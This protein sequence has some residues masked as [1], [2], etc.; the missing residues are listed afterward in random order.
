MSKAKKQLA[1]LMKTEP[2]KLRVVK[3]YLGKVKLEEDATHTYQEIKLSGFDA[4]VNNLK[5]GSRM[6]VDLVKEA[7]E[8]RLEGSDDIIEIATLLNCEVWNADYGIDENTDTTILKFATQFQEPLNQQGLTVTE[9]ELLE[10]WH[11]MVDYAVQYLKPAKLHYRVTWYKL[12]HSSRI[13]KWHNILLVVRLLFTLPVSNAATERF[14]STL[15]RVKSP[16]RSS[17]SQRTLQDILRITTEGPP[18]KKYD[19]TNAV[20]AW[21]NSKVRRP[22]QKLKG[23]KPYK[24]RKSG[25]TVIPELEIS[26]RSPTVTVTDSDDS[27]ECDD[28]ESVRQQDV[29]S[30]DDSDTGSLFEDEVE[31]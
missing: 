12:F 11:D 21:H 25:K 6:Y 2:D 22:N 27:R 3:Y 16:K 18:L 15:K 31:L 14:F 26:T 17:L 24:K 7:I 19:A 20:L 30:G 4:A 8:T 13:A 10:E 28:R 9:P 29:L 23:R 5:K 1:D